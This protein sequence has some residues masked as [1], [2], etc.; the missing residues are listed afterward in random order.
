M[1]GVGWVAVRSAA[2]RVCEVGVCWVV[3]VVGV[4]GDGEVWVEVGLVEGEV[5]EA[6][7]WLGVR[8]SWLVAGA[9]AGV[10]GGVVSVGSWVSEVGMSA[11]G[12]AGAEMVE[13]GVV[14]VGVVGVRGGVGVVGW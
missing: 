3:V 12:V 14:E 4:S 8:G 2:V 10:S 11:I 13:A 5:M 1:F 9:G 6:G 7:A